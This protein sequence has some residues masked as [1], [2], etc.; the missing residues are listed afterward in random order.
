MENN[1]EQFFIDGLVLW[2]GGVIG[3]EIEGVPVVTTMDQIFEYASDKWIDEVLI[4]LADDNTYASYLAERFNEMGIVSH[5]RL[6]DSRQY[7]GKKRF[8]ERMGGYTVLTT[9]VNYVS[10]SQTVMK[11][12]LDIAGGAGRMLH[13]PASY[14]DP[15]PGHLCAVPWP[16]LL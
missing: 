16:H 8:I 13:H 12:A 4:N 15:G 10:L 9:S 3:Q 11:R 14:A 5:I 1:Y 7:A 6:L 2:E